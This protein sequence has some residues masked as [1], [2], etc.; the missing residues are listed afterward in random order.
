MVVES[1]SGFNFEKHASLNKLINEKT[2][3]ITILYYIVNIS[4]LNGV[5]YLP[6]YLSFLL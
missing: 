6:Y 4:E 2:N 3:L 5:L 1:K